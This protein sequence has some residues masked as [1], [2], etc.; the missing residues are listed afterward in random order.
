M[1]LKSL[2]L[3]N[4]KNYY[5]VDLTFSSKM[6][7]FI[8]ANGVG[9]TNLLDAIYYLSMCKSYINPVDS[10]NIRYNEEFAVLQGEFMRLE[11]IEKIY[12]SIHKAKKKTFKRNKKNYRKLSEH[13]G[14]LPV[15]MISPIDGNLI[16]G[17]S[18]ERRKYLDRVISQY[19]KAYLEKLIRYNRALNQRNQL[20]KDFAKRDYFNPETL[21]IWDEQLISLGS[22][23]YEKRQQFTRELVP[24][25]QTFYNTISGDREKVGLE[26]SSH[27][28]KEGL[29]KLL[30][31]NMEKD[32]ILQYTTT[33]VHKDDLNLTIEGH[34]IKKSGSQGQ[35]KTFLVALKFAQF[36]FIKKIKDLPPVLLL[37]DIFDKFDQQRVEQ[38]I[39]L[40][41]DDNFG[42]IFI[43]DTSEEKL[44]NILSQRN[45][46]YRLFRVKESGEITE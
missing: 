25:F 11:K 18:E 26:Y 15:V 36:E 22:D 16:S 45:I 44:L 23:I 3:T 34:P 43:T 1:Y 14:L 42:Q 13:I 30:T 17:G 39:H 24:V 29:R 7:C 4:F 27:L 31:D 41:S 33:G 10:Q 32:R 6:N 40:V 8:G 19:D 35:Q 28:Q 12:C 38:I 2:Y 5:Q 37:D 20:L 9:K 46:D 21:D